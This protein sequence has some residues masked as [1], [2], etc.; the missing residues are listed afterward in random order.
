MNP[1]GVYISIPFCR[2]K[3]T[4]CNFASGVSSVAAHQ[5]YVSRLCEEM[6]STP[7]AAVESIYLGGGTPSVLSPFLIAELAR[8]LR[9]QFSITA[10]AEITLECAPG[11][12]DDPALAAMLALGVNRISFGVQSLVDREA[13]ATGRF[14]TREIVLKDV[15]RMRAAGIENLSID[16]IAGMPHQT[17][18]SWQES[19]EALVATGVPH[20]S[21]YMLEID[22]DSR[23]GRELIAGGTR[24]HAQAVP[25]EE[26]T[27]E[28]YQ[29][30]IAFL[31]ANGLAQYEIS[32]FGA[33]SRHNLKYW[34]REPYLGF[35]LDAHS[36]LRS[37]ERRFS[38]TDVLA[39]YLQGAE[40]QGHALTPAE[41]LEE[42]WFLGLRLN[43]GV[44]WPALIREFGLDLV[45][46]FRPVVRELCSLELVS[47]HNGRVCLTTRG[48]LFSN[49]VFARFLGVNE[50]Q[51][52]P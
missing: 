51:P 36:M 38:N 12:L 52:L 29:T 13:A 50:L 47:D 14:H 18:A 19:L 20:A 49:E 3:C 41:A 27:A 40:K 16:L 17:V 44:S 10:N 23:L 39:D 15:Q 46:A 7:Q 48:I 31:G 9:E 30:A 37:P 32:N 25:S 42:A 11:Q 35:G 21:V 34:R 26:L 6:R 24:Y 8:T 4:Y 2:A 45:D 5:Q 43:E 33:Q 22:D 28:M 1:L